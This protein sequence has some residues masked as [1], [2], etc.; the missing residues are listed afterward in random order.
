MAI[1]CAEYN[2]PAAIGCGGI[3]FERVSKARSGL[4][5]CAGKLIMPLHEEN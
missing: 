4:L 2:L 1:R 3:L 5:D